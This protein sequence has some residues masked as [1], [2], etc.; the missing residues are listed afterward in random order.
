MGQAIGKRRLSRDAFLGACSDLWRYTMRAMYK[1]SHKSS[2][3]SID[4]ALNA[5]H[6][7]KRK[8]QFL[9]SSRKPVFYFAIHRVENCSFEESERNEI[10]SPPHHLI[11]KSV[12]QV[13]VQLNAFRDFAKEK[14]FNQLWARWQKIQL[15][16]VIGDDVLSSNK[17]KRNESREW[18]EPGNTSGAIRMQWFYESDELRRAI[19]FNGSKL[20]L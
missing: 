16:E 15:W 17:A 8:A 2:Y 6:I 7:N 11:L 13:K 12:R 14:T 20:I 10:Q 5:E 9:L 18:T 4:F 3:S 1:T 19:N